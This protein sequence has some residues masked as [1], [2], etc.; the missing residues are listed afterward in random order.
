MLHK[1]TPFRYIYIVAVI[2]SLINSI[3][4]LITG[5]MLSFKGYKKFISVD[6][7]DLHEYR[8]GILLFE[9]LDAFMV[10]LVFM[11]F[12][13]GIARIFIFDK[14]KGNNLPDWLNVKTLEELKILLWRTILFVL[15][16]FTITHIMKRPEHS[17]EVL[18]LPVVILILSI[19]L[20]VFQKDK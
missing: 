4:F 20:Y 17:W 7:S 9:A 19:A 10:S 11:I 1:L 15:V 13:I 16:T 2:V 18:V 5:L 14:S 3:F 12:G 6:F 8:P